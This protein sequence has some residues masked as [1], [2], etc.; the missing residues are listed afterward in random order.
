MY[1]LLLGI[2]GLILIFYIA[3]LLIFT[4]YEEDDKYVLKILESGY[5]LHELATEKNGIL[6]N[7]IEDGAKF[8]LI[9]VYYI[10]K[11]R[12][13]TESIEVREEDE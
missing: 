8:M 7:L 10:L 4:P 2:V 5:R 6:K 1:L 12:E 11:D 13:Y 9:M 3:A